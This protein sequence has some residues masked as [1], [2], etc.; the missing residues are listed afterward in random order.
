MDAPT[1]SVRIHTSKHQ[2]SSLTLQV[3]VTT[4]D[5]QIVLARAA[6]QVRIAG[7]SIVGYFL[8]AASLLV[9]A[10]WWLRTHRRRR[11]RGRHAR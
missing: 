1:K 8:T 2:G 11:S 9:L 10:Y 3:V 7:T 5:N 6:I 4:P